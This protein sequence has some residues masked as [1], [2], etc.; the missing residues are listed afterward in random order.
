MSQHLPSPRFGHSWIDLAIR[1]P[2]RVVWAML[3]STIL[4][5]LLAVAPTL[6]PGGLGPLATI[7]VDVDPENMLEPDEPA[8]VFHDE[9]KQRFGLHDAVV[10]GFVNETDPAGVF[11]PQTLAN[12][13][14]LTEQAKVLPGVVTS[15]VLSLSTVDRIERTG[16]GALSFDWLMSRPPANAEEAARVRAQAARIP[17]LEGTLFSSDGRA[18]ILYLPL[19]KKSFAH[20]VAGA[21]EGMIAK[22]PLRGDHVHIAGLPIAEE[23]FGVE[24][25]LQMA[26]SAPL[27]M[28]VIFFLMWLFFRHLLVIVAPMVVAM[29]AVLTTMGLL[30]ATGH[31]IHIMSSMIP[32]F[33]MPIAVLDAVHII[34]DFFDRYDHQ[35]DR[36]VQVGS[37]MKHLFTPMLFT[38]LTTAAGFA[39]LALTPIPPVRVFGLFVAIGVMVAWVWTILFVPAY[40]VLLADRRLARFG[41]KARSGHDEDADRTFGWLDRLTHRRA[42][43]ILVIALLALGGAAAGMT[44]IVVNDNPTRWF[45]TGHPIRIADKELNQHFGG[46]YDAFLSL[47]YT[48]PAYDPETARSEVARELDAWRAHTRTTFDALARE[49]RADTGKPALERVDAHEA[50]LRAARASARLPAEHAAVDAA[51]DVLAEAAAAL[52][53]G[54]PQASPTLVADRVT[55]RAAELDAGL[56]QA[57]TVLAAVA[58]RRPP[59][60]AAFRA[61]LRD[62][63]AAHAGPARGLLATF[64]SAVEQADEVWKQPAMLEVLEGLQHHLRTQPQVG[65]SN[66][67]ADIVKTVHRDLRSGE[68]ADFTLP[69]TPAVVAQSLDQFLSSHRKDDLWHFV[70]PDFQRAVV[71][72]Q[73]RSGDN[74]D[75]EAVVRDVEAYLATV[76]GASK[77]TPAWFGL[78]YINVVWQDRMVTGMFEAFAG[79]F[80]I[81]LLMMIALNRSVWWGLFSMIP[82]AITVAVVYG[83]IGLIGKDYDMPVAVLS[84][85]SLGL[86]VDYAIHFIARSRDLT[87]LHGSWDAARGVVFGEPAR[88][89]LRNIIVI[90]C[91]FLPLLLAPL[92]PYQTVGIL[93]AAILFLAGIATLTI[94][95]ALIA[96]FARRLFR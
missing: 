61:A 58:A 66:S 68:P 70:T 21:L 12:L 42:R 73:L 44:R 62:G 14:A 2:R 32:I 40:L 55:A 54:D 39:S 46:T 60:A 19:D 25:F 88:A 50:K 57:R 33:I 22:L 6:I 31:T 34:S 75:M 91:G 17:F 15:D 71:W 56:E 85:L 81:V 86:A 18:A 8:R 84:S 10:V 49:L 26:I 92:V 41:M 30:V 27:A 53:A 4:I 67:V 1:N 9:A 82:L 89:I 3:G 80:V 35:V 69:A 79:S 74:R 65:K 48:P 64:A 95:P 96:V 63:L 59:D 20:D 7:V 16:P 76:P 43:T 93:I 23:T 47:T 78:T 45:E 87:R 83:V 28:L 90:G 52:E 38:S 51:L 29:V 36:K 24:M 5:A 11:N 72:V 77:L 94:L 13:H 37:V